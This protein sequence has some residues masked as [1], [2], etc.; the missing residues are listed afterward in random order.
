MIY[1]VQL[2]KGLFRPDDRF[3]QLDHA[4]EIRG[5]W[6]R[7]SLLIIVST[8]LYFL[9]GLLG[10]QSESVSAYLADVGNTEFEGQKMLFAIGSATWGLL[11]PLLILF[12]PAL[13]FWTFLEVDFRKLLVLQSFVFVI[14][15]IEVC[16][17]ILLNVTL[18][19]PRDSS[20]FS[21]GVLAQYVTENEL[22]TSF[23]SFIT[24]F[25]IW[26]MTLQ[27]KFLKR[28]SEKSP[29]FVLL[30]ILAITIALWLFSALFTS[31]HVDRLF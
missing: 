1:Q 5:L 8:A 24:L 19:I 13:L 4:E 18:A 17:L 20:P 9:S 12:L 30:L 21:L 7:I 27:Y 16:L 15:L 10:I 23:F 31:I 2:V 3:Y 22:I 25:H 14:Y 26:A 11:Y 29:R 28:S 6:S